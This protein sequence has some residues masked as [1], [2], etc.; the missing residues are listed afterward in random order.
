MSFLCTFFPVKLVFIT[1][2]RLKLS[3]KSTV[4]NDNFNIL[5][6]K[7][8]KIQIKAN[9]PKLLGNDSNSESS[10][11]TNYQKRYTN[12]YYTGKNLRYVIHDKIIGQ[13]IDIKL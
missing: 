4:C 9:R 1:D 5:T 11:W 8:I 12:P 3:N 13:I 6:L 2:G 10:I 7:V